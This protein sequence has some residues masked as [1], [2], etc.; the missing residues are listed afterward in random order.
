MAGIAMPYHVLLT[1]RNLKSHSRDDLESPLVGLSTGTSSHIGNLHDQKIAKA[2][3]CPVSFALRA[4]RIIN[5]PGVIPDID[6]LN[7]VGEVVEFLLEYLQVLFGASLID[8]DGTL[9]S[10]N[11]V[12]CVRCHIDT[13]LINALSR[14]ESCELR[15]ITSINIILLIHYSII[16]LHSKHNVEKLL[17]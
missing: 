15:K 5:L 7:T 17:I 2:C 4:L 16:Q 13:L 6:R 8:D 3:E 9:V 12:V 11:V 14:E 10:T 1:A